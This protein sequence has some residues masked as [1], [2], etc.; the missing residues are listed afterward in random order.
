MNCW[1]FEKY[2]KCLLYDFTE[3]TSSVQNSANYYDSWLFKRKIATKL[4]KESSENL[5]VVKIEQ[6]CVNGII[7]SNLQ[8]FQNLNSKFL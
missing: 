6:L 5:Y 7:I 8:I 2:V 1:S 3:L 4:W